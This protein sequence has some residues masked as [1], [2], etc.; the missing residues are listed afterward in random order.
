MSSPRKLKS[1]AISGRED[2]KNALASS[3]FIFLSISFKIV[4]FLMDHK[5]AIK[6]SILPSPVNLSRTIS[7]LI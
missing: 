3:S 7:G 2:K 4:T 1:H 6:S 5:G